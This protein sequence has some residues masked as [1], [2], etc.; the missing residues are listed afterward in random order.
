M[1]TASIFGKQWRNPTPKTQKI[2]STF[3]QLKPQTM[4]TELE[5]Q[6]EQKASGTAER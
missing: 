2:F 6:N 4:R 1:D 5:D 3:L